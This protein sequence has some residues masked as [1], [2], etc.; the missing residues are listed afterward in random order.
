MPAPLPAA[1]MFAA[2]LSFVRLAV[3]PARTAGRLIR[4]LLSLPAHCTGM[5]HGPWRIC[6]G[7]RCLRFRSR[8]HAGAQLR[9][10][11]S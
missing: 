1:A 6:A 4:R 5:M 7:S 9:N 8:R 3:L 11:P 2:R 10:N